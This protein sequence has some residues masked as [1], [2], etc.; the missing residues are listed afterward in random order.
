MSV[1]TGIL[2]LS[3]SLASFTVVDFHAVHELLALIL[4]LDL[5]RGELGF[6]TR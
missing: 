6:V 1:S 2:F 3:S 5:L 4:R